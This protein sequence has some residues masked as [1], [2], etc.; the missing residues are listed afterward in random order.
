MRKM[1]LLVAAAFVMGLATLATRADDSCHS[2]AELME[3][4]T[5]AGTKYDVVIY[6][7]ADAAKIVAAVKEGNDDASGNL[8]SVVTVLTD[9]NEAVGMTA[10]ILR[11]DD[12]MQLIGRF[13]TPLALDFLAHALGQNPHL[14][15]SI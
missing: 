7:G 1:I 2:Y 9:D 10:I 5:A 3:K 8:V 12:C 15:S 6:R 4:T 11:Q 13:P 14:T